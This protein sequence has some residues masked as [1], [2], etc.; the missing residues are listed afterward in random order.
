MKAPKHIK[1]SGKMYR[2][3]A[4]QATPAMNTDTI[5]E[6][7]GNPTETKAAPDTPAVAPDVADSD[8]K[9]LELLTTNVT[10]KAKAMADGM[11]T[12]MAAITDRTKADQVLATAKANLDG[13]LEDFKLLSG[14][15]AG[16]AK[17]SLSE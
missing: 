10:V 16:Y 2:L 13:L 9:T 14:K 15:Y 12:F 1:Y 11:G 3:A 17:R 7:A 6:T 5:S 8:R 4:E